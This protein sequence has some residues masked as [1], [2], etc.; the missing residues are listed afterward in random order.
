MS[1][2]HGCH[3]SELGGV[4]SSIHLVRDVLTKLRGMDLTLILIAPWWPNQ[5]WFLDLLDLSVKQPLE[6]PVFRKLLTQKDKT[7]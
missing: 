1:P 2:G 3:E 6:L 5:S 7:K 4:W